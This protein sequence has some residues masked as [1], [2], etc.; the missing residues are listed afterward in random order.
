MKA[1]DLNTGEEVKVGSKVTSFRGEEAVL[2]DLCRVNE[3]YYGGRRSGKVL[4][5]WTKDG[6]RA[7]YYDNVFNLR[8]EE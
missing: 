1:I 4:V 6:F 3:F 7:E 5:Q 2:L 8:V